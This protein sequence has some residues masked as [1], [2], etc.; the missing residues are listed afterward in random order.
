MI[1]KYEVMYAGLVCSDDQ[2]EQLVKSEMQ[3]LSD[4]MKK[5]VRCVLEN[6]CHLDEFQSRHCIS[7]IEKREIPKTPV[8][9]QAR[10]SCDPSQCKI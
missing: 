10:I 1:V 8:Q 9:L 6:V 2:T 7:E 3:R 5:N 4:V